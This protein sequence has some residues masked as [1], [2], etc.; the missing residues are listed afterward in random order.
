MSDILAGRGSRSLSQPVN[1][2]GKVCHLV[3]LLLF[4]PKSNKT[5]GGREIPLLRREASSQSQ[6]SD[7]L[8]ILHETLGSRSGAGSRR[9]R[10][11]VIPHQEIQE[12]HRLTLDKERLPLCRDESLEDAWVGCE[13]VQDMSPTT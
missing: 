8:D 1:V 2:V 12:L 13:E 11:Q 9:S 7:I 3:D 5:R 4:H 10:I 6:L